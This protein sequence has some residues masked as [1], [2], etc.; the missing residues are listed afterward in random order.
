MDGDCGRK[1]RPRGIMGGMPE[2]VTVWAVELGRTRRLE[3]VKGTL[4]LEEQ[5]LVFAPR[6][7]GRA[8]APDR[9]RRRS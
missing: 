8:D 1:P 6:D 9:L 4:R 2:P 3:D 7:E 5:A